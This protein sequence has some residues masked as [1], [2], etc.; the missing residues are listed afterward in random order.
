MAGPDASIDLTESRAVEVNV[1]AWGLSIIAAAFVSH[2]VT[3]GLGRHTAAVIAGHGVERVTLTAKW[4]LSSNLTHA[5]SKRRPSVAD[6][7][8]NGTPHERDHGDDDVYW[9]DAE[10]GSNSPQ[11]GIWHTMEVIVESFQETKHSGM[12]AGRRD[13]VPANLR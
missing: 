6:I 2:S 8:L 13:I 7:P 1:V 3:L 12:T 4:Q 10:S 11:R 9:Y 5:G